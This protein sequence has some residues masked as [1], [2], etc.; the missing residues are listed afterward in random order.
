MSASAHRLG[1][2]AKPECRREPARPG[3][4]GGPPVFCC[5]TAVRH[6]RRWWSPQRSSEVLNQL[7]MLPRNKCNASLAECHGDLVSD[8]KW[9]HDILRD[10]EQLLVQPGDRDPVL[11][12]AAE[13]G[14][15]C[16]MPAAI[17]LCHATAA[18]PAAVSTARPDLQRRRGAAASVAAGQAGPMP[19]SPWRPS[20]THRHDVGIADEVGDEVAVRLL[21]QIAR[22]AVL[23]DARHAHH[24][25]AVGDRQR[26]LLVVRHV[27][28]GER[29]A[30]AA[31]RGFR[32]ARD[33]AA[34]RPGWTAARRTAAPSAPARSPAPPRRAA[35]GRPTVHSAGARRSRTARPATASPAP[36]PLPGSCACRRRAGRSRR[37]PARVMC[38]NS[39]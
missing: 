8:S 13:I 10:D 20:I 39:A 6:G 22:R 26:L 24:D 38:G 29:Q 17:R 2:P 34:W 30:A 16:H 1:A 9:R 32:R 27:D 21:V 12:V 7:K 19:T 4:T 31:A 37:S 23:R 18:A 3:R 25:D 15:S 33:G 5:T 35:A 28:H 14:R 11:H 36:A